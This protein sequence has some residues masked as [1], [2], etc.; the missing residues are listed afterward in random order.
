[1]RAL[2]LVC[3]DYDLSIDKALEKYE[4]LTLY[5]YNIQILAK[6]ILKVCKNISEAI[7][8]DLLITQEITYIF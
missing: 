3:N 7:F 6:E 4:S 2:R 5:P 1:M 8:S